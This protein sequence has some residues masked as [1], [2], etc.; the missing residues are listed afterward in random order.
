MVSYTN[1]P[2]ST[3]AGPANGRLAPL[4]PH[5]RDRG[6]A[7]GT[8]GLPEVDP[9]RAAEV[10]GREGVHRG[11]VAVL[12]IARDG[13]GE[14][15]PGPAAFLVQ[16][17]GRGLGRR[18]FFARPCPPSSRRP[19]GRT[20]F[21]RRIWRTT[22]PGAGQPAPPGASGPTPSGQAT[23][24]PNRSIAPWRRG[25]VSRPGVGGRLSPAAR[26]RARSPAG[27]AP[28]PPNPRLPPP[29]AP[30]GRRRTGCSPRSSRARR[31]TCSAT[32]PSGRWYAR[33]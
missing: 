3:V 7:R 26:A 21:Y 22:R 1:Q 29:P 4:E 11:R 28:A 23:R 9:R 12:R 25:E 2:N 18:R 32:P 10:L 30:R 6:A 20:G 19:R 5:L 14:R 27:P 17:P 15:A 31:G 13:R 24:S 16:D 33:R 8:R